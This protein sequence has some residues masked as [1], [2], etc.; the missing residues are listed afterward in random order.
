MTGAANAGASSL[1]EFGA[2]PQS[3]ARESVPSHVNR[4]QSSTAASATYTAADAVR[5][6]RR[7]DLGRALYI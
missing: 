6:R 4:L 7:L 5:V 3:A 2:A 1:D